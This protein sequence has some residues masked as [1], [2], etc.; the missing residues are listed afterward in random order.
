MNKFLIYLDNC[1]YNRPYDDF[2]S[3]TVYLEAEAKLIIHDLVKNNNIDLA[4][5]YIL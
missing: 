2:S 5:S 4:W 1:C 3:I